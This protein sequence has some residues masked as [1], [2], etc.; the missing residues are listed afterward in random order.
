MGIENYPSINSALVSLE[1]KTKVQ[2]IYLIYGTLSIVITWLMFG[3]GAQLLCNAIG[4]V[5]PA[6]YS[7]KAL[8]SARK[9]DDTQWGLLT[10][11]HGG[12]KGQG[13]NGQEDKSV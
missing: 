6:Y 10:L 11:G 9:D 1:K 12:S 4:F 2:K 8:E 13:D 7:I 5:Y 3:Y